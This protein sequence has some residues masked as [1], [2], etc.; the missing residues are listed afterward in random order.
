MPAPTTDAELIDLIQK[1]GVI[2]AARLTAYLQPLRDQANLPAEPS[3]LARYLVRDGLLTCFQAEQLL[4]GKWKRFAIGKYK[5][6]ERLGGGGM[7]QVF[8]CEHKLMRRRVAIKVLPSARA[9]DPAS[10]ERFYR[11]AR[12]AAALD[13][14]NLVRAYDID[15]DESLHFLVLEYVDGSSFQDIVK[16]TGPLDPIRACHYV[17]QAALGLQYAYEVAGLVHRDIKPGNILVDRTGTVKILDVGLARFFQ[18]EEDVLTKKY[19]ESIMGTADYVAPEQAIDSHA[20]DIRADIYSLGATFYFL[21]AGHPPFPDG[22]TTQ[23]LIWHQIRHPKPIRLLRPEVPEGVAA[24]IEHMMAK[25]PPGRYQTP[26]DLAAALAPFIQTPILPPSPEEMPRLSPAA[27]GPTS[28]HSSGRY[29]IPRPLPT[30]PPSAVLAKAN[31][32]AT[33]PATGPLPATASTAPSTLR[34]SDTPPPQRVTPTPILTGATY[35]PYAG[36][37]PTND[38][39][40]SSATAQRVYATAAHT[41][42]APQVAHAPPAARAGRPWLVLATLAAVIVVGGYALWH[43][44][45]EPQVKS[46]GSAGSRLSIPQAARHRI[47]QSG[48]PWTS[49]LRPHSHNCHFSKPTTTA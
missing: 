23:K 32:T 14:P 49:E 1:S 33:N 43:F 2:E 25:E 27:G 22:S 38:G 12:A 39:S 6:L 10:L 47:V 5:V 9:E 28:G 45:L 3:R 21:L 20:V 44:V 36:I 30:A 26:A 40:L 18:D 37:P 34:A 46:L 8:L 24:V 31:R 16:K 29:P 4:Q 19:E 15:Q 48:P 41:D 42:P 17:Y 13:H 11:E 7:G 35:N